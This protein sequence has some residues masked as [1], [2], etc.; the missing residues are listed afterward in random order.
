MAHPTCETC[1]HWGD[2]DR[3]PDSNVCRLIEMEVSVKRDGLL[4]ARLAT[5]WGSFETSKD[6]YCA[7]H[8]SD[9][10]IELWLE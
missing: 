8:N 5:D 9:S 2:G 1:K 10:D 3:H 7:L 4:M 6:F